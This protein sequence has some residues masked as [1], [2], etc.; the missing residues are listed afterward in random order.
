MQHV[1]LDPEW[2]AG[3]TRPHAHTCWR[4]DRRASNTFGN[5]L[6]WRIGINGICSGNLA[7][8]KTLIARRIS[9]IECTGIKVA[10]LRK[11]VAALGH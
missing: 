6:A 9:L 11:R 5:H 3:F 2:I 10:E 8:H 4:R 1:R 7:Q